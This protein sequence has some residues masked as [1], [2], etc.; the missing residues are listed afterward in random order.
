M[1]TGRMLLHGF[2][3]GGQFVHRF[4]YLHPDRL[5]AVSIGAP[6]R[7]TRIS[8]DI[9]WWL[10][11]ADLV[12]R[13]GTPLDLPELRDTQVLMVVGANDVETWE[14]AEPGLDAGGETR[15]DRLTALHDNFTRHGIG[16]RLE[17]VPGV[18]HNGIAVMPVVQRF[19]SDVLHGTR[20]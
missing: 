6:G 5:A 16:A 13:F 10:G 15:V 2:S 7:V 12:E 9:P 14:I 4:A 3:G 18:A 11:T 17:I 8:D 20:T 19:F 1:G